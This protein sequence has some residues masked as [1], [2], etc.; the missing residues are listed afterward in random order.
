MTQTLPEGFVLDP[1]NEPSSLD[2][3]VL[4]AAPE[5]FVLDPV[6]Q[7][8]PEPLNPVVGVGGSSIGL[9]EYLDRTKTGSEKTQTN[10]DVTLSDSVRRG[11]LNLEKAWE[12]MRILQTTPSEPT[13]AQL[14]NPYDIAAREKVAISNRNRVSAI[15]DIDKELQTIPEAKFDNVQWD[16]PTDVVSFVAHL[17]AEYGAEIALTT[18]ATLA[19]RNP[20][21]GSGLLGAAAMNYG[22]SAGS[23][24]GQQVTEHGEVV[25]PELAQGIGVINALVGGTLDVK[26]LNNIRKQ[27][28]LDRVKPSIDASREVVESGLKNFLS[29]SV[30][31]AT[32][33]VGYQ[34]GSGA[35]SGGLDAG[36]AALVNEFGDIG[37]REGESTWDYG[38]RLLAKVSE[39]GAAGAATGI[40]LGGVGAGSTYAAKK[41]I[42]S[43]FVQTRLDTELEGTQQ[44]EYVQGMTTQPETVVDLAGAS[45]IRQTLDETLNQTE[46]TETPIHPVTIQ[47]VLDNVIGDSLFILDGKPVTG[48]KDKIGEFTSAMDSGDVDGASA[49]KADIESFASNR[50]NK[51]ENYILAKRKADATNNPVTLAK[52]DGTPYFQY[53]PETQQITDNPQVVYPNDS[54]FGEAILTDA[55]VAVKAL[56]I[57]RDYEPSKVSTT[58][59]QASPVEPN[60]EVVLSDLETRRDGLLDEARALRDMG[61]PI[62]ES[63]MTEA[64]DVDSQIRNFTTEEVSPTVETTP[65]SEPVQ[66]EDVGSINPQLVEDAAVTEQLSQAPEVEATTEPPVDTVYSQSSTPDGTKRIV[67]TE[68]APLTLQSNVDKSV[69]VPQ[70]AKK[71]LSPKSMRKLNQNLSKVLGNGYEGFYAPV[72]ELSADTVNGQPITDA[73]VEVPHLDQVMFV[74]EDVN[75]KVNLLLNTNAIN[76]MGADTPVY[77]GLEGKVA[78]TA[79]NN[80]MIDSLT[81]DNYSTDKQGMINDI[82]DIHNRTKKEFNDGSSRANESN[83][84]DAAKGLYKKARQIWNA[85][86]MGVRKDYGS[87]DSFL[88]ESLYTS[89]DAGT[90]VRYDKRLK[91]RSFQDKHRAVTEMPKRALEVGRAYLTGART[92][93]ANHNPTLSALVSR[94]AGS[95]KG[96]GYAERK[97]SLESRFTG[98]LQTRLEK[99]V[100]RNQTNKASQAIGLGT[101]LNDSNFKAQ[102]ESILDGDYNPNNPIHK[103]I[104]TAYREG[105]HTDLAKMY[106]SKGRGSVKYVTEYLVPKGDFIPF[107][108]DVNTLKTNG[109]DFVRLVNNA[110]KTMYADQHLNGQ[111]NPFTDSQGNFSIPENVFTLEDLDGLLINQGVAGLNAKGNRMKYDFS[112]LLTNDHKAIKD[113]RQQLSN[114]NAFVRDPQQA[115]SRYGERMAEYIAWA[116]AFGEMRTIRATD[117][118][119]IAEIADVLGVT[120]DQVDSPKPIRVFDPSAKYHRELNK[121]SVAQDRELVR[122]AIDNVSGRNSHT[123]YK[124]RMG[125]GLK[126]TERAIMNTGALLHYSFAGLASVVDIASPVVRGAT[127]GNAIQGL[128]N[129]LEYSLPITERG[130]ALRAIMGETGLLAN[131]VFKDLTLSSVG[132]HD[133]TIKPSMLD[134]AVTGMFYANF[135]QFTSKLNRRIGFNMGMAQLDSSLKTLSELNSSSDMS[136]MTAA[137]QSL[138]QMGLNANDISMLVGEYKKSGSVTVWDNPITSNR[139]I[140]AINEY[141]LTTSGEAMPADLPIA[142]HTP[143]IKAIMQGT[144]TMYATGSRIGGRMLRAFEENAIRQVQT[145]RLNNGEPVDAPITMRE[146]LQASG[147]P[148]TTVM[149]QV[150]PA[151]VLYGAFSELQRGLNDTVRVNDVDRDYPNDFT[152]TKT[153]YGLTQTGGFGVWPKAMD[154]TIGLAAFAQLD[155]VED[156]PDYK[157]DSISTAIGIPWSTAQKLSGTFK[158][159]ANDNPDK[160]FTKLNQVARSIDRLGYDPTDPSDWIKASGELGEE[161]FDKI[162]D[163]SEPVLGAFMLLLPE[164]ETSIMDFQLDD[165]EE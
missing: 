10:D 149:A 86:P 139:A 39:G 131:N 65:E 81:G 4:D 156:L 104:S 34:G 33:I 27:T 53:D 29:P 123:L 141:A 82:T 48:F 9:G 14:N 35:V 15:R 150:I 22:T 75:G 47:D 118:A 125:G 42:Q 144:S 54:T 133:A 49:A 111:A 17:T 136:K 154:I 138:E 135:T 159:V 151:M 152:E 46:P 79:F 60:Q 70:G 129:T 59:E 164:G 155:F 90:S 102:Y 88:Q 142:S 87:F 93:I 51:L 126:K 2:G 96:G 145:R 134:K 112:D 128:V 50:V 52:A 100:Q 71:E 143:L 25:Q 6:E 57:T 61:E 109:V 67:S 16:K 69:F 99:V 114:M 106:V 43:D 91:R 77:Y 121:I 120:P 165:V 24:A 107:A 130:K 105:I 56:E 23:V 64:L 8:T 62:P 28:S 94:P 68:D 1:V 44:P 37:A 117:E 31:D 45:E 153:Y 12:G 140:D 11:M 160:A 163:T 147:L 63:L 32:K 157:K 116:E 78:S 76:Q 108:F 18:L 122:A 161:L 73:N 113:L 13:P 119:G 162:A 98:Q 38:Q 80:H 72:M 85:F 55:Q 115:I 101:V 58:P 137:N 124:G 132:L 97:K 20:A 148:V 26:T 41:V 127:N 146:A 19:T 95:S 66:T 21:M 3:F 89:P 36:A 83:A 74:L 103:A 5:G 40:T 7:T 92:V 158:D 84:Y 110:L 30:K